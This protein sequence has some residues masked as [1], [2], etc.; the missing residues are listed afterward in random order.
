MISKKIPN[1]KYPLMDRIELLNFYQSKRHLS[2]ETYG[3]LALCLKNTVSSDVNVWEYLEE[4]FARDYVFWNK[5]VP[6]NIQIAI[7]NIEKN[8]NV[9]YTRIL[10]S[11]FL[12][13]KGIIAH[14]DGAPVWHY[15]LKNSSLCNLFYVE[16][17]NTKICHLEEKTLYKVH[18]NEYLHYVYNAGEEERL[19]LLFWEKSK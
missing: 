6:K 8:L 2:S 11:N 10:F 14:K 19:H 7:E 15:P 16:N 12:P 3:S 4:P 5:D 17:E 1:D 9:K 13:G 18:V